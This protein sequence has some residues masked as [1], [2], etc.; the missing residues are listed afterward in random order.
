M[1]KSKKTSK[2]VVKS[3]EI[4]TQ[5]FADYNNEQVETIKASIMPAGSTDTELQLFVN[6]CKRT[7]LD[8]FSR[9]IYA[10]KIGGKLSVQAT[11]D[12]FR[13]IAERSQKYQ[14]QTLPLYLKADGVTWVE[15]WLDEG[16]PLACK[17]GVLKDGFKEPLYAIAKWK[18]YCQVTSSG[19]GFMWK[20]MPEVMIAKVAEALALRKAFPNDLSGLYSQEEMSQVDNV[21]H[22]NPPSSSIPIG[23]PLKIGTVVIEDISKQEESEEPAIESTT[24][25]PVVSD[26][27][28]LVNKNVE[29]AMEKKNVEYLMDT[30]DKI[31]NSPKLT[32]E[33]RNS[34]EGKIKDFIAK[35]W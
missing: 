27:F 26:F 1:E 17:V 35:T 24:N 29:L 10:T 16:F 6:Q 14:G 7:G 28:K 9:Q 3:Q 30:Q 11:I 31:H 18:S 15:V 33:Q 19:V 20:K 21:N 12:G 25:E 22:E 4:S 32:E 2:A 23:M 5:S 8:P 13:L 34:L